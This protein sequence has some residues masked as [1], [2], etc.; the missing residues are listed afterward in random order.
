[1]ADTISIAA[2]VD[3]DEMVNQGFAQIERVSA[4]TTAISA[5]LN[6]VAP[7]TECMGCVKAVFG[8]LDGIYQVY[9]RVQANNEKCKRLYERLRGMRPPLEKL[10][11]FLQRQLHL[12]KSKGECGLETDQVINLL[13]RLKSMKELTTSAEK[14]IREWTDMGKGFF[15]KLKKAFTNSKY[16]D[17]F[18]DIRSQLKDRLSDLS[19]DLVIQNFVKVH[20]DPGLQPSDKWDDEDK[21][22]VF[23]TVCL[24]F[25]VL[26]CFV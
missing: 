23:G 12:S 25:F 15:G 21:R 13:E 6:I 24:Q 17:E 26:F 20:T 4:V 5:A 1:M 8:V 16:A 3:C 9:Q 22:F 10:L 7:L 14:T 11:S 2:N 18:D 19:C